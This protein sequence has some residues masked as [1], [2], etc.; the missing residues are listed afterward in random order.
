MNKF[1]IVTAHWC[2]FCK[3]AKDLM[4]E[5][6]DEYEEIDVID[7]IELLQDI[8]FTSVPQI[9]LDEEHI[10]GYTELEAYYE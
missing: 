5:M 7:S 10:G 8:G 2:T 9:F 4:K 3:D 6:G 1:K